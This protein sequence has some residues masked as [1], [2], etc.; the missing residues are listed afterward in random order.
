MVGAGRE[1]YVVGVVG[2]AR[3]QLLAVD[4]PGVA[5]MVC[6]CTKRGEV[7]AGIRLG[8]AD[9]EVDLAGKNLR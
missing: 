8:V 1:P 9:R 2:E 6:S 7:S 5:L 4:H 3:V